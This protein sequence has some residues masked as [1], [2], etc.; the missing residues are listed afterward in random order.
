MKEVPAER[1]VVEAMYSDR[2]I[3]VMGEV[4]RLHCDR[5]GIEVYPPTPDQIQK[6][7][8]APSDGLPMTVL[9]VHCVAKVSISA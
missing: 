2:D 1:E 5:C 6:W 8:Q 4:L 3:M 7:D 9:C